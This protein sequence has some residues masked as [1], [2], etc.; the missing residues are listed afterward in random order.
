ML[1]SQLEYI[2]SKT[3]FVPDIAVVLG[4]GLGGFADK[5]DIKATIDYSEIEGLPVSTAPSHKGRFVFGELGGKKLV[6]MQGRVHLYEG[7]SS[8]QIASFIRLMYLM[9]ARKLILTNASGGINKN[10]KPG[11]FMMISDHISC[12]I[13]S[14]LIGKNID[15]LGTRFPDMSN[16]YDRDLQ[17][18]IKKTAKDNSINLKCG[19]YVQLKGPQFETPA[20]IK[21][22]GFMG[23]DAV[24]MSTVVETIA[25]KHCGFK[26]CAI[27]LVANYACGIID[28]P[29]SGEEVNETANSV[30]KEFEKLI[31][32]IIKAI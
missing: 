14:P 32:E 4:S 26:V 10:L 22:L 7:Y 5:I 13:D 12:F 2:R 11:D 9:G 17:S 19:T 24:G 15:A 8:K 31:S 6:L 29:L 1:K 18:L 28:K 16:A 25:A 30:S 27:S 21:M 23:A 20:E 3:D